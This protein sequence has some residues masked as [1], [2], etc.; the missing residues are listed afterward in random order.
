MR[1][2][3]IG[4]RQRAALNYYEGRQSIDDDG[5]AL[6]ACDRTLQDEIDAF[7]R[8]QRDMRVELRFA[9]SEEIYD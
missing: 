3:V 1:I 8:G 2:Q 9:A 6:W 7:R 4:R 5:R